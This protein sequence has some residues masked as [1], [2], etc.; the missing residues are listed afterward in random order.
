MNSY[1]LFG[2]FDPETAG[3]P[4]HYYAERHTTLD[5]RG[6]LFIHSDS[7]WGYG[8]FTITAS[9]SI[10]SGEFQEPMISKPVT[11]EHHAWITSCCI[12]YNC[13]IGHH[14]VISIGSVVANMDVEPYTMVAGNPAKVVARWNG[15]VWEKV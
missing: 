11:V 3:H 8:N 1:T 6:G 15:S 14:A 2:R 13:K 7:V 10:D 5:F 12:L 4:E 9:H